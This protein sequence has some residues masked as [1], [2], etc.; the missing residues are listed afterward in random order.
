MEVKIGD[1]YLKTLAN[2]TNP[3]IP[4]YDFPL[5]NTIPG[6]NALVPIGSYEWTTDPSTVKL[7]FNSVSNLSPKFVPFEN[8]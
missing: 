5:K 3:I 6:N 1:L 7:L 2:A 8:G 4:F